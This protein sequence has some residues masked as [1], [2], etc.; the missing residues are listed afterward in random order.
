MKK[1]FWKT[2]WFTALLVA[3]VFMSGA[4]SDLIQSLERKA[5]DWG[6]QATSRVPSDKIAI[7][8][9][10]DASITNLGRWP[11]PREIQGKLLDIWKSVV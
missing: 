1:A 6:V 2:D 5:Y 7:I 4:H 8:A 9:I 10:D 3:L 11:W